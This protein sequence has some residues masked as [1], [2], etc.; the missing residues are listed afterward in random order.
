MLSRL[1]LLILCALSITQSWAEEIAKGPID[2]R[3]YAFFQLKNQLKVLLVSDPETERAAAALRVAVGSAQDPDD[4]MGLAH[5]LE[6]MLFLGTS[7]YPEADAYQNFISDNGGQHNAYTSSDHTLYFFDINA[8]QLPRALD[9]FSQFFIAP[10]FD[11]YYVSR[12][13]NVVHSEYQANLQN[14]SRRSFDVYRDVINPMHP[15]AKFNVGSLQTLADA[16]NNLVRDDLLAFYQAHYSSHKMI[17]VVT[18]KESITELKVLAT[19]YFEQVPLREQAI[20]EPQP[21]LPF[22]EDQLPLEIISQPLSELRQMSMVFRVPSTQAYYREKPLIFISHLLGHEGPGSVFSILKN[23]GLAESF[24]TGSSDNHDGSSDFYISARLTQ[25]GVENRGKIRSL[26]FSA[27]D[28]I[29]EQG[30]TQWRY[31]EKAALSA[32]NFKYREKTQGLSTVRFLANS[33]AVYPAAEVISA[34]YLL[35]NFDEELIT[36]YLSYLH[37]DNMMVRSIY[38]GAPT[39]QVSQYYQ[40]PYSVQSMTSEVEKTP[41]SWLATLQLP[42]K[43]PFIPEDTQVFAQ[44]KSISEL[45][46][47]GEGQCQFWAKQNTHY[48]V[49]KAQISLRMQSPYVANNVKA[50]V[51]N[52]LY[53]GLLSD[54][55]N[56]KKYA[57]SIAGAFLWMQPNNKGM[58][59]HLRGYHDKLD[60][61]LVLLHETM[62]IA[63]FNEQRFQQVK[64]ELIRHWRNQ[65]KRAPYQQ[66]Y[67]QLVA[68]LFKPYW[69]DT[70][71]ADKLAG[72][73][74]ADLKAF[75]GRWRQDTC[76]QGMFYGNFDKAL[77]ET[78]RNQIDRFIM[79]ASEF[80]QLDQVVKLNKDFSSYYFQ[81]IDHGDT[82]VALYVQSPGDTLDDKAG[83]LLLRQLMQ[84]PF[85]SELRTE[86]QLGYIVYMGGLRLKNVPGSV[87]IVQSPAA[88]TQKIYNSIKTFIAEFQQKIPQDISIYQKAVVALLEEKPNNL[89]SS[90][91]DLWRIIV[92]QQGKLAHDKRL[93]EVIK[94]YTA[95][96]LLKYYEQLLLSP[97]RSLWHFSKLPIPQQ[98]KRIFEQG[99]NF[100]SYP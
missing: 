90:A 52:E 55:L 49:P 62:A 42:E 96:K 29:R 39:D 27:I 9:R 82:A 15:S 10:L 53:I 21:V 80:N 69:S 11:E 61:L 35:Q 2:N 13:R 45:S 91:D 85:Y 95:E 32:L 63:N 58:D 88:N 79:P 33:L 7:K 47:K 76:V 3:E 99:D 19:E 36:Q 28:L 60:E 31:Q 6:H 30:V 40:V 77:L 70:V 83:M 86:Q 17:L 92:H 75:L 71:K 37:R 34:N 8:K 84:S 25:D 14:E 18:G 16:P 67:G 89:Y 72:L 66:L 41:E 51:L 23:E 54:V 81:D 24:S 57:A 98:A 4:R 59:I 46:V 73:G 38:P 50:S 64:T 20:D 65:K 78:W 97:G 94:S 26:I 87:F 56:E 5:F 93:I 100:Y 68:N 22:A 74:L 44:D 43:N 48:G 1:T 12:E